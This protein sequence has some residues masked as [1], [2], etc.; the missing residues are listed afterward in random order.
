MIKE[1]TEKPELE[2]WLEVATRKLCK[3][4]KDRVSAEIID[5]YK[6]A[7][8]TALVEFDGD[9]E[10]HRYAMNSLG[11]PEKANKQLKKTNITQHQEKLIN[12]LEH[13]RPLYKYILYIPVMVLA[14]GFA[15]SVCI[16]TGKVEDIIFSIINST[17]MVISLAIYLLATPRLFRS[18]NKS[19]A[20]LADAYTN[21][22]FFTSAVVGTS[23]L[24]DS[25]HIGHGIVYSLALIV[26][27]FYYL[28]ISRKLKI[29][30]K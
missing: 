15:V 20:L 29:S 12:A 21:W 5:H 14:I 10:A 30:E 24:I 13:D 7:Y 17:V 11:D 25:A 18:G 3:E 2:N 28:P 27:T 26:A 6:S 9:R 19:A 8:E 22:A 16:D 1:S 4:A 23:V